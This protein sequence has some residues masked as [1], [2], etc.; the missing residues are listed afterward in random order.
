M[1]NEWFCKLA[2]K[3]LGPLSS[4]QLIE[5]AEQQILLP[6]DFVRRGFNRPWQP[7]SRVKGLIF[8]RDARRTQTASELASTATIPNIRS[9]VLATPLRSA[10]PAPSGETGPPALIASVPRMPIP[11]LKKQTGVDRAGQGDDKPDGVP[12]GDKMLSNAAGYLLACLV[13]V[14]VMLGAYFFATRFG[15]LAG[16]AFALLAVPLV[17][18]GYQL[19]RL[20]FPAEADSAR[21]GNFGPGE[22]APLALNPSPASSAAS[23]ITSGWWLMIDG[24]VTGPFPASSISKGLNDGTYY[25]GLLARP[26]ETFNWQ[27]LRDWQISTSHQQQTQRQS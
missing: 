3:E 5:M 7:A 20:I 19:L 9:E 2:D 22:Q 26:G 4:R 16:R 8:G 10:A 23:E 21:H 18:G 17:G 14:C 24:S 13:L 11:V 15:T 1:A 25:P 27:P 12:R 6:T